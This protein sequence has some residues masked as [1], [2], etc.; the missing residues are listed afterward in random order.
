MFSETTSKPTVYDIKKFFCS[1]SAV[2]KSLLCQV[3]IVLKLVL[4][5]PASNST[6]ERSFSAFRRVK[7]YLRNTMGQERLIN[8]LMVLHVHKELT[9]DFDLIS[10][11]NC[12]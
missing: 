12:R 3:G 5:M 9:D 11:A 6:S 7:T 4:I 2:Q 8:H 1:L 10:I